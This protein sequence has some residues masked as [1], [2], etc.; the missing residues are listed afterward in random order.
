M[1]RPE[2]GIIGMA[3]SHERKGGSGLHLGAG[4]GQISVDVSRAFAKIVSLGSDAAGSRM[5]NQAG[6]VMLFKIAENIPHNKGESTI[7][8]YLHA[9]FGLFVSAESLP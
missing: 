6:K 5:K 7:S 3:N 2:T 8:F 1:P 9:F 4:M